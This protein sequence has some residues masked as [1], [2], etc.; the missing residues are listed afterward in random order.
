M[1]RVPVG[2]TKIEK[3]EMIMGHYVAAQQSITPVHV[4]CGRT[5]LSRQKLDPALVQIENVYVAS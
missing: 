3:K 1:H 5:H 4:A 2:E